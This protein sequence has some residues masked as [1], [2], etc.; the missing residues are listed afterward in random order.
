MTIPPR[1]RDEGIAEAASS[2]ARWRHWIPTL[3]YIGGI[4]IMAAR[5]APRLPRIEHIDKYLH[6]AAYAGLALIAY[7]SC[8]R[9]LFRRPAATAMLLNVFVGLTDEGIQLLGR[10]RTADVRDLYADI[11]GSAAGVLTAAM[12]VRRRERS[13]PR[14]TT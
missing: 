11:I 5:P 12:L 3:L 2:R 14:R 9:S 4:I 1:V 7:R 10:V 8:R 13:R 6:A